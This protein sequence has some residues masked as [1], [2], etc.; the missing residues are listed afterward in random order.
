MAMERYI[1][2]NRLREELYHEA[3]ETDT[4]M[5]RWDSGCWIRYKMFENILEKQPDADVV[6]K[7]KYDALRELYTRLLESA[8]ILS[9]AVDEY[10]RRE[11]NKEI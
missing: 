3:F 7:E 5:Q 8:C 9:A 4:E 10:Q 6:S 1:D 11:E 2:A